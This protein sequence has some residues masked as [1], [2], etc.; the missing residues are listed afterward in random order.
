MS[1]AD[2]ITKLEGRMTAV[3]VAQAKIDVKLSVIAFLGAATVIGMVSLIV[4]IAEA[5]L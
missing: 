5:H 2:R 3:E 4:A 1:D